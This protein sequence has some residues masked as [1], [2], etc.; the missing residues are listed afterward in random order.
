MFN[1]DD[2]L[3]TSVGWTAGITYRPSRRL[4]SPAIEIDRL[5]L[6]DA[7]NRIAKVPIINSTPVNSTTAT[8]VPKQVSG[9]SATESPFKTSSNQ[10]K[11]L[12]SVTFTVDPTDTNFDH[13]RVWFTG[14]NGTSNPQMMP[15]AARQSPA[16]LLC[17]TTGETVTVTI[18]AISASG[19]TSDFDTAPTTT[20][21]LDGVTSAPPAP[22][23]AQT[24]LPIFGGVQFAF[25]IEAGLVA[26]VIHNYKI[27]RNTQNDSAL[28]HG[29]IVVQTVPQSAQSPGTTY[30]FQDNNTI[31][32]TNYWYWVSAVNQQGLESTLT[33]AGTAA[34]SFAMPSIFQ[35][36][37]ANPDLAGSGLLPIGWGGG[38]VTLE[39]WMDGQNQLSQYRNGREI[40]LPGPAATGIL[41]TVVGQWKSVTRFENNQTVTFSAYVRRGGLVANPTG[42]FR[43]HIDQYSTIGGVGFV[44]ST[45][46]GIGAGPPVGGSGI[47]VYA[48][49]GNINLNTLSSVDYTLLR[50]VATLT[51]VGG[52]NSWAFLFDLNST[53]DDLYFTKPMLNIGLDTSPYSN[54]TFLN[55][56]PSFTYEGL[57]FVQDDFLASSKLQSLFNIDNHLASAGGVAQAGKGGGWQQVAESGAGESMVTSGGGS[58][59]S[60]VAQF[61][62]ST[63]TANSVRQSVNSY[64][65]Q[66]V[67]YTVQGDVNLG[68]GSFSLSDVG[69]IGRWTDVNNF[70][71]GRLQNLG[72]VVS[73][74]LFKRVA[75]AFTSLGTFAPGAVGSGTVKLQ[76]TDGAKKVFWNG[77]QQISSADNALT[78]AGQVGIRLQGT[79]SGGGFTTPPFVDNFSAS[80]V[81]N[82]TSPSAPST[83]PNPP[84]TPTYDPNVEP[85]P[86]LN[87]PRAGNQ[88]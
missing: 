24:C 46:V 25:N 82:V 61:N 64:V 67:A 5:R 40:R 45:L 28:A 50:I 85:S 8:G 3:S 30:V 68:A 32:N 48:D 4:A 71:L 87:N 77:V 36:L 60:N 63:L 43:M 17:D 34:P 70:Y 83:P 62:L 73:V 79:P 21:I 31:A 75:G 26:D 7:A 2:L 49:S 13:I 41:P 76:I 39:T 86:N 58:P 10:M 55:D 42:T 52:Q 20:V 81:Q 69:V 11:S 72:G 12:V 53:Q 51:P 27:Y 37:F 44:T 19:Q 9:I 56:V 15:I 1:D 54:T 14:Y 80:Y 38:S 84:S 59:V 66:S 23:I 78:S 29:A 65:A 16:S 47:A 22:S 35:N 88:L 74:D 33:A 18:Q 6:Q 57:N